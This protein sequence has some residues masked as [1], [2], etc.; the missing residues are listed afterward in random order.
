MH[1]F[2]MCSQAVR[3]ETQYLNVLRFRH[4]D[5]PS[6]YARFYI[7]IFRKPYCCIRAYHLIWEHSYIF[8]NDLIRATGHGK[9]HNILCFK[10]LFYT[11][12]RYINVVLLC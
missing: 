8:L 6:L 3:V 9:Q 10:I 4:T 7:L 11:L 5:R 12:V 1:R 2:D